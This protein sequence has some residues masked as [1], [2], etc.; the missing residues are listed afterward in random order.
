M[1]HAWRIW[2]QSLVP[3]E[4]FDPGI[5]GVSYQA[6]MTLQDAENAINYYVEVAEVDGAK[7]PVALLGTPGKLPVLS[8][9]TGQ[10]RGC[11]VLPGGQQ[12]LAVSNNQLFL[13]T[14]TVPATQTSI[15]QFAATMVG[16][17][18][19]NS[20]PVVM[21]DNGVLSN[22]SGGFVLIVDGTFGYYYLIGGIPQTVVFG[23]SLSIGSSIIT[24][25]GV[26]PRGLIV[27]NTPTLSDTGAVIPGGTTIISVDTIG[28]SITMS[29]PAIGN[30]F[31]D[32]VTLTIPVFGRITDAG[33]P[34]NPERLWF[35][36]GWIAVN[37]GGSRTFNLT[38][39]IPYSMLF[40]GAFFALKDSSTD[41]LITHI[42]NNREAWEIG[43]RT[44][45]VW[46]NNAG[47]NANFPFSRVPGVG[48]QIGCAAKHSITRLGASLVWLG[49]N[50]Q[51]ENVVVQTE[52]YAW[53]RISNHAVE[54]AIASY[55][56]VSDAIG[57]AY[58]EAGH[59]FY[60]LIFPTADNCWVYDATASAL[61]GKPC[62]HQRLSFDP[63]LGIYHRDRSN[64]F[65]DFQDL[66]LV[67]D[68]QTGQIHQMTRSVYTDAGNPLRAQRRVKHVWKKAART[69]VSQSSL[70]IE[71][72]P[73][74]GLQAGQGSSPQAMVRWSNDGGFSWSN[75]H[76]RSIGKA[77][78]TKNRAKWN[79]LGR[80]R[81]RVY[82]VNFS[83]PTPRDIIGATLF[84][85][86]EDG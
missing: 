9:V 2:E 67:G 27:A 6:A 4:P 30:S 54:T 72:T 33:F 52:Q 28:L 60:V 37:L 51:G 14:V 24:L 35:I 65:M 64:C 57:F 71:F 42:E 25:P 63:N 73:G 16:T 22:G 3:A 45:E 38:G 5:V 13:I 11:W 18:L 21:R 36:E 48:P 77:G 59:G 80:A 84:A 53:K 83:D 12:A 86:A 32:T 46:F 20:G 62:W 81:D 40:P 34:V 49:K 79:R 17:L 8:T 39:P 82:E 69:R 23:A 78:A 1:D 76:W 19:T 50:E 29:A 75:E 66:R 61:M 41:N 26:L 85:E 31:S 58:E 15:A 68:Y 74:V 55:P 47:S 56:L 7:E 70:Q 10:V 43:E 44:S